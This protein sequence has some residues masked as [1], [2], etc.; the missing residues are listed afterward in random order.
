LF[1]INVNE[2]LSAIVFFAA[3]TSFHDEFVENFTIH[4]GRFQ[5][6]FTRCRLKRA[7]ML[8]G[9]RTSIINRLAGQLAFVDQIEKA[10]EKTW[11]MRDAMNRVRAAILAANSGEDTKDASSDQLSAEFQELAESMSGLRGVLRVIDNIA[12]QTNLLALN[13]TI[14]AARAGEAGRGFSVVASEVKKLATNTKST[15]AKTQDSIAGMETSLGQL[16]T[17]IDMSH[18]RF[19]AGE[20]RYKTTIEQVEALFSQSG[21]IDST[22]AG[23]ADL[24]VQQRAAAAAI[25][26]EIERLRQLE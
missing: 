14:E 8:N 24:A 21:V 5:N 15:L 22:L 7:D 3:E 11:E 10:L 23:L 9:F 16:G 19:E 1:G 6:Y 4:Y 2:T 26:G 13:A 17:I 20:T 25:H 18:A 12:S